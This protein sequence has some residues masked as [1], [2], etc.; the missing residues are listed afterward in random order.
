MKKIKATTNDFC[1]FCK[2]ESETIQHVFANC[3]HIVPLWCKLSMHILQN[4]GKRI[5]FHV[6]NILFGETSFSKDNKIVNFIILYTKQYIYLCLKQK[7]IPTLCELI[8]FLK[9]KYK[10]EKY[11]YIQKLQHSTFEKWWS[12]WKDMFISDQEGQSI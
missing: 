7:R 9:F 10:I 4:T 3:K 6:Y 11:A 8:H 12:T 2:E 1:T 5:V